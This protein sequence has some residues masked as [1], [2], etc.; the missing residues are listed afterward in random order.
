MRSQTDSKTTNADVEMA[1]KVHVERTVEYDS[2][3]YDRDQRKLSVA[4]D[5]RSWSGE[6]SLSLHSHSELGPDIIAGRKILGAAHYHEP[7]ILSWFYRK[8]LIST[9]MWI[10]VYTRTYTIL[11]HLFVS[12]WG[13]ST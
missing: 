4:W 1:V 2:P 5:Y 10:T 7:I 8:G 6:I 13:C 12:K 9:E 11:Y 3:E